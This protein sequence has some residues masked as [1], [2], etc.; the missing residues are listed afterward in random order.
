MPGGDEGVDHRV[1]SF[2]CGAVKS[3]GVVCDGFRVIFDR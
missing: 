3:P 2:G 1:D